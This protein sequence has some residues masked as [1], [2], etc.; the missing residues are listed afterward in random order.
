MNIHEYSKYLDYFFDTLAGT[1][2]FKIPSLWQG[3]FPLSASLLDFHVLLLHNSL[4]PGK[5]KTIP[6]PGVDWGPG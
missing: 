4:L 2:S 3:Q 6:P 1:T 5:P